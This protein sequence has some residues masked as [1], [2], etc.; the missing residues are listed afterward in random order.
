MG[1]VWQFGTWPVWD[2]AALALIS[3]NTIKTQALVAKRQEDQKCLRAGI[4]LVHKT[5]VFS[6]YLKDKTQRN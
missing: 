2:L 6:I 3:G 4:G 1:F 5:A